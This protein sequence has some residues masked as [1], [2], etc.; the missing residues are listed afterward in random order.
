MIHLSRGRR[1]KGLQCG[2]SVRW[3]ERYTLWYTL[4]KIIES[5][6][7]TAMPRSES[8]FHEAHYVAASY[9]DVIIL[10]LTTAD[11]AEVVR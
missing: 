6:E 11:R 1:P 2:Q 4:H 9:K 3:T 7:E 5:K 8:C 10:V